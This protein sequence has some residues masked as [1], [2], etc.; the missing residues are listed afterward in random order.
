MIPK[1][2]LII[3]NFFL[4]SSLANA[5]SKDN[6]ITRF[7]DLTQ[8]AE[9]SEVFNLPSHDFR[10]VEL[11]F[12][13]LLVLANSNFKNGNFSGTSETPKRITNIDF[14]GANLENANFSHTIITKCKF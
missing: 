7:K 5:G 6:D 3:I 8:S 10:S 14:S 12:T 2:L 13:K 4:I 1:L 9:K 11:D